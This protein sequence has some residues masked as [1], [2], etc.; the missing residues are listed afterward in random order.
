M[1]LDALGLV[2][3]AQAVT[4]TAFSTNTID[5]GATTP[6]AAIGTGESMGFGITIDVAADFTTGD[7]TYTVEIVES[8]NANL[9]TPTVIASRVITAA[10]LKAGTLH[11]LGLPMGTPSKRY[12]GLRYTTAGTTPTVTITA[13]LIPQKMFSV[14]S[15]NYAKGY[16]I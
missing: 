7:E 3:D 4:A 2:S 12:L 8:D 10:N 16:S 11:W 1:F 13:F 5:L 9:S 6:V 14:L 15:R